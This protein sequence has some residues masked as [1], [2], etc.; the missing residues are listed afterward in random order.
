V[1]EP[2]VHCQSSQ[3]DSSPKFGTS[4]VPWL[5]GTA[6]W[7]TFSAQQ[8]ILGLIPEMDGFRVDPCIPKDWKGFT[9]ERKFRGKLL[10][11]E[12]VNKSGVCTGVKKLTVNGVTVEGNIVPLAAMTDVT[13]VVAEM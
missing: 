4:R 2:F 8:G 5:S 1:V 9:A 7:A 11:I 13:T 6:S 10:K 12:V 3:A